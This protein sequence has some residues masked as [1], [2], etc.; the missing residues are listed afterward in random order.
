MSP[1][2]H[3]EDEGG[4]LWNGK[5]WADMPVETHRGRCAV[6]MSVGPVVPTV[7]RTGCRQ[8]GSVR[9]GARVQG[10]VHEFPRKAPRSDQRD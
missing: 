8:S 1:R 9:G 7:C 6:D 10:G 5:G 3:L 2:G 4:A